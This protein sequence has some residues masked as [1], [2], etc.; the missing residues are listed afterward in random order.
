MLL[1]IGKRSAQQLHAWTSPVGSPTSEAQEK[2]I[3]LKRTDGSTRPIDVLLH[4]GQKTRPGFFK[5]CKHQA[6]FSQGMLLVMFHNKESRHISFRMWP[7]SKPQLSQHKAEALALIH[8]V[9]AP[10]L[11]LTP[12]CRNLHCFSHI[13]SFRFL[14]RFC[15][16]PCS[17]WIESPSFRPLEIGV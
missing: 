4:L 17:T 8:S 14:P 3:G 11:Y 16:A 6:A 15:Q 9:T 1:V 7:D 5:R 2:A 13:S 10:N 12:C